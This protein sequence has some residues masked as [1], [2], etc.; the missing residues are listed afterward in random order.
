M[1]D[2]VVLDSGYT[3]RH[4][5]QVSPVVRDFVRLRADW[6]HPVALVE[7][8]VGEKLVEACDFQLAEPLSRRGL[9][10]RLRAEKRNAARRGGG[11]SSGVSTSSAGP[12]LSERDA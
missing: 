9:I 8:R 3:P 1:G 11:A 4:N 7:L 5:G 12:T 6:A 10:A 2:S